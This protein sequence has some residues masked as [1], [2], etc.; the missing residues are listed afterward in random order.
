MV[1]QLGEQRKSS[2][3][4][5]VVS[6]VAN[7]VVNNAAN[8]RPLNYAQNEPKLAVLLDKSADIN[9]SGKSS[10]Q[11]GNIVVIIARQNIAL[12]GLISLLISN[13]PLRHGA[14]QR[15]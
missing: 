14:E 12:L 8:S 11:K 13:E 1:R 2:A 6:S 5:S 9:H 7:S 15:S 3:V 10:F 4:N